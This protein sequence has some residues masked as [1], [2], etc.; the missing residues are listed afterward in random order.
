MYTTI[1]LEFFSDTKE[2]LKVL[3]QRLKQAHDVDVGLL[4]PRHAT[5]PALV[6][7]G[8]KKG[9]E[10]AAKA[11]H[12]VALTLYS[13]VHEGASSGGDKQILLITIE[14][15]HVDV[16]SLS[17]EEIEKIILAAKEGER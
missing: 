17:V 9:G 12:Q 14:G 4:E 2:H 16:E 5:A 1:T 6:S 10:R 8:I 11:A 3:E 13:F 15:D 7:I